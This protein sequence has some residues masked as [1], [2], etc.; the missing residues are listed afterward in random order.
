M[1]AG[2]VS[3]M[4]ALVVVM[5]WQRSVELRCKYHVLFFTTAAT[6]SILKI[7]PLTLDTLVRLSD[8]S[9]YSQFHSNSPY[10]HL[11][12]AVVIFEVKIFSS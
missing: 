11:M 12:S 4:L 5:P 9:F 8:F 6:V 2:V 3:S 10:N 1:F 7:L